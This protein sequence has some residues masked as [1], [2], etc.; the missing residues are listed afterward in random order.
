MER[1]EWEFAKS[2]GDLAAAARRKRDYRLSRLVVWR[3][4]REAVITVMTTTAFAPQV[5]VDPKYQQK[6]NECHTRITTHDRM[7]RE[8][9][10]WYQIMKD[11][12]SNVYHLNADDWLYFFEEEIVSD[13]EP[14]N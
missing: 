7:A 6:L 14:E 8:Y 4:Q 11:A 5:S 13:D 3:E 9:N 2:A 12:G 1:G 10:G